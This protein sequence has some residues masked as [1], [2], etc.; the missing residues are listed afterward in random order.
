M[1]RIQI[2]MQTYTFTN[3]KRLLKQAPTIRFTEL[4]WGCMNQGC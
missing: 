1:Y 2:C 4:E 3:T